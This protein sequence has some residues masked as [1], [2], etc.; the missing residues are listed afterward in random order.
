LSIWSWFHISSMVLIKVVKLIVKENFITF[1][2]I[3]FDFN[4]V[5]I[6]TAPNFIF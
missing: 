6:L 4:D 2:Y 5:S 1:W 3:I